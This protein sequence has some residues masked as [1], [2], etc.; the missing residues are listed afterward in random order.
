MRNT[1]HKAESIILLVLFAI[2]LA[3]LFKITIFRD[4]SSGVRSVNLVPLTTIS[5]YFQSMLS[6]NRIIGIS[7]I[8]GNLIM[9]CPLGYISALLFP[10]MRKLTRILILALGFSLVIE[11]FQYIFARGST[12]IDD[13][14]LNIL[15]GAA[16]YWVYV[17]I[18]RFLEPKKYAIFISTLM[19]AFTCTGF[20]VGN[21]DKNLIQGDVKE[22]SNDSIVVS[23]TYLYPKEES[24]SSTKGINEQFEVVF[25]EN[26]KITLLEIQQN[27]KIIEEKMISKND[28]RFNDL[29]LLKTFL[30]TETDIYMAEDVEIHRVQ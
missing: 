29:I 18:S 30:L 15:G 5:E 21:N 25:S 28:I 22:I 9:F 13:V 12:D 17:L 24:P 27:G 2:Y 20:F 7:N 1:K 14:I 8:L 26:C 10:E 23:R 4:S 16:G 6:G 3:V 11:V 19:I